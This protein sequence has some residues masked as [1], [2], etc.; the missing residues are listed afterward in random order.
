LLL[1]VF[2]DSIYGAQF[3]NYTSFGMVV[4]LLYYLLWQSGWTWQAGTGFSIALAS[5]FF[6]LLADAAHTNILTYPRFFAATCA[7]QERQSRLLPTL[8]CAFLIPVKLIAVVFLPP[9][10]A[11]DSITLGQDWKKLLRFYT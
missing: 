5:G 6:R 9:A 2:S 8:I 3:M 1:S 11:A 7:T 10:L 4:G